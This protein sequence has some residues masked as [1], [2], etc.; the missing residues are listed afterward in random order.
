M[1]QRPLRAHGQ[2]R[3]SQVLTTFG[4]GAMVDLPNH[5]VIVGGLEHW[6]GVSDQIFEERLVAKLQDILQLTNLKLQAPPIDLQD[7]NAPK[8]G[9]TGWQFPEWFVAQFEVPWGDVFRSRPLLN[10]LALVDGRY[11]D[12]D[13]K[14]RPV[15]PSVLS[16][17][18]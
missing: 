18:A 17:H 2:L 13:R 6:E 7:L 5:A 11:L 9:I 3:Q 4:P 16:R 10:R 1:R 8:T 12:R 14:K 15:V